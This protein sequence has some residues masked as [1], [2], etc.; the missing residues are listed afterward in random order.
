MLQGKSSSPFSRSQAAFCPQPR[1]G[2][3][4]RCDGGRLGEGFLGRADPRE[5]DV[6]SGQAQGQGQ[7]GLPVIVDSPVLRGT[8]SFTKDLDAA[9]PAPDRVKI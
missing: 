6:D 2:T 4:P 3:Q 7:G 8:Q 5:R 9:V 1:Q